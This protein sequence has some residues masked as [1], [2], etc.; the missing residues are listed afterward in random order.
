MESHNTEILEGVDQQST[1]ERSSNKKRLILV[2]AVICA[3]LLIL[4][5]LIEK[6]Q[7][8]QP[9]PI[10]AALPEEGDI[11]VR[12]IVT[13]LPPGI[14]TEEQ[15]ME[16]AFGLRDVIG[17]YYVL[18]DSDP[19][20]RKVL[21]IPTGSLVDVEGYFTPEASET[22]TSVGILDVEFVG[23]ARNVTSLEVTG[24]YICLNT[25][26]GREP[27]RGDCVEGL[28][29]QNGERYVLSFGILALQSKNLDVG[30]MIKIQG[31]FTPIE[32]VGM[33]EWQQYE[34]LG[35]IAA[36]STVET[37]K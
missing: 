8:I 32:K 21:S 16:C 10:T 29:T 15:T 7:Q 23:E 2:L 11:S 13:C 35:V 18:R 9:E 36:T 30:D 3:A 34:V 33:Q 37:I 14:Q 6:P 26:N 24:T 4:W 19:Q 5:L 28:R 25:R 31:A 1:I 22:Y 17:R 20:F 27:R 12:G